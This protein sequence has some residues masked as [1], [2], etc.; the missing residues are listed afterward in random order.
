[1]II[2]SCVMLGSVETKSKSSCISTDTAVSVSALPSFLTVFLDRERP[3]G[4]NLTIF[5]DA[6]D[7]VTIS[8]SSQTARK[9]PKVA[10]TKIPVTSGLLISISDNPSYCISTV[11]GGMGVG[12]FD[13]LEDPH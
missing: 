7:I 12:L 4:V 10:S 13:G 3:T 8:L 6:L 2:D 1:M 5:P 11:V 9:K